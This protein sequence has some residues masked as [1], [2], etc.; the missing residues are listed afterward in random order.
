MEEKI[1][2]EYERPKTTSVIFASLLDFI[3]MSL[4]S[5]IVFISSKAIVQNSSDYVKKNSEF[6][7]LKI[8]SELYTYFEKEDRITDIVTF[9][10]TVSDVSQSKIEADLAKRLDNFYTFMLNE[11]SQEN[12]L[13]IKKFYD[14]FRLEQ[15]KD[16]THYFVVSG[17][18]VVKNPNITISSKDYVE[19]VYK[20]YIDN[21][22]LGQFIGKNEEAL[23]FQKY[24]SNYLLFVEIPIGLAVGIII[25]F[26]VMPLI[27]TRGKR[28]IG[29][30]IYKIS[31]VDKQIYSPTFLE[32]TVNFLVFFFI[33]CV[34]SVVTFCIPLFI[35]FSMGV[36]SKKKQNFHNYMTG[37]SLVD[38]SVMKV[39]KSK[40]D[41]LLTES[42]KEP[43]K[44][45]KL[46]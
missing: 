34:L 8:E 28:T 41:I 7:S 22:A 21:Y 24:F 14:D 27:F 11:T 16:G 4:V 23:N 43:T 39:F 31:V 13:E 5:L 46:K 40:D 17:D 44:S 12:Y 30:L 3:L 25:T 26:Y 2:I 18:S 38:S 1:K 15:I 32:F 10:N 36:F 9:Y 45:F 37:F 6:N 19:N 42:N 35:S 20:T 33:E 29:K